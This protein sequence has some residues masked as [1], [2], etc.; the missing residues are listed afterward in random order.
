M[1]LKKIY[2]KYEYRFLNILNKSEP[3][4]KDKGDILELFIAISN[5]TLNLNENIT[6]LL[7]DDIPNEIK[8]KYSLTSKDTGIDLIKFNISTN[9][10]LQIIQCKN[11]NRRLSHHKLGTFYYWMLKLHEQ[12]NNI[13]FKLVMNDKTRYNGQ[14]KNLEINI[15][16]SSDIV[17][18]LEMNFNF[19]KLYKYKYKF[20]LNILT[21]FK[22]C[23]YKFD[24]VYSNSDSNN[25]V[26]I[27]FENINLNYNHK[28]MYIN[29]FKLILF[30]II[31]IFITFI[32]YIIKI[33]M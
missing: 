32:L 1:D 11:Y 7:Y 30:S 5:N 19:I 6:T 26:K 18:Y 20:I 12:D 9:Q 27:Y 14:L 33:N 8:N 15:V 10:I 22:N 16:S 3:T 25:E 2:A 21:K 31:I 29:N 28:N 4:Y 23:L 24:S 17:N 13:K